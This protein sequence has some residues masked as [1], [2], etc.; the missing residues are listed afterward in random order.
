L[1]SP[2][3]DCPHARSRS[4]SPYA[5]CSP[6]EDRTS[7]SR[8]PEISTQQRSPPE[9]GDGAAIEESEDAMAIGGIVFSLPPRRS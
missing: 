5:A 2:P 1:H 9:Q 7:R 3:G 8:S 4:R 6:A